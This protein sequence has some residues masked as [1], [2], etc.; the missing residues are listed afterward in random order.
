M[1]DDIVA[2]LGGA[3]VDRAVGT[4]RGR[5]VPFEHTADP[6]R[7]E[8]EAVGLPPGVEIADGDRELVFLGLLGHGLERGT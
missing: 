6:R 8:G 5:L 7:A 2:A 3:D 4:R 1:D